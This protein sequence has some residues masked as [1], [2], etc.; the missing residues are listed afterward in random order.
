MLRRDS[1][2]IYSSVL[3][4]DTKAIDKRVS[5][6]TEGNTSGDH[7]TSSDSKPPP[8]SSAASAIG[9]PSNRSAASSDSPRY[10]SE[11]KLAKPK[12]P[13]SAYN[14]FFQE[15][16]AKIIAEHEGTHPASP[17][18]SPSTRKQRYRPN[19]T[20]FEDLAKEISKRWKRVGKERLEECTQRANADMVRYQTELALYSEQREARLSAK[21]RAQVATV[22][23][24][25]WAQYFASAESQKP[26]R[27]R[28][29][30]KGSHQN[31]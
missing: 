2:S 3:T 26:P 6:S 13:L 11:S 22:S 27:K 16:R 5:L 1:A 12:R 10:H 21:Q 25:T 9:S 4:T 30:K 20:G 14:V 8:L 24:E 15:E 31:P 17:P 18:E 7:Q 29:S 28:K 19:G 23:E